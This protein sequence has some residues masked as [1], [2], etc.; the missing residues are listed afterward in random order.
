[1]E[2][3]ISGDQNCA[4]IGL[5]GNRY[6][7]ERHNVQGYVDALAGYLKYISELRFVASMFDDRL[8]GLIASMCRDIDD[9]KLFEGTLSKIA[10]MTE[11]LLVEDG[12]NLQAPQHS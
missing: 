10:G 1:M 8:I 6:L 11:G 12:G 2:K 5:S 3:I 4:E 7:R 9:S